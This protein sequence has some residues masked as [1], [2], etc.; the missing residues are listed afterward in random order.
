MAWLSLGKQYKPKTQLLV[1]V[2]RYYFATVAWSL[3]KK[4]KK[5]ELNFIK[6]TWERNYAEVRSKIINMCLIKDSKQQTYETGRQTYHKWDVKPNA[7]STSADNFKEKNYP[8]GII[9]KI[10]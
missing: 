9:N 8:V 5:P 4:K 2:C 6:N 3:K 7:G 1:A 10:I